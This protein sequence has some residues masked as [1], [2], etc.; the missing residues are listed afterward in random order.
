MAHAPDAARTCTSA[1]APPSPSP[2]ETPLFRLTPGTRLRLYRYLGLASWNGSPY[3]FDL[4]VGRV[5]YRPYARGLRAPIDFHGLLLSCRTIH[6]EAA[7]LLYSANCFVIYYSPTEPPG[8]QPLRALTPASLRSL[9]NLKIVVNEAACHRMASS[10]CISTCCL[11][12]R[13]EHSDSGVYLCRKRH[14]GAHQAPFLS[15]TSGG[16]DDD[17][18][19]A[20]HDAKCEL[21]SVAAHMFSSIIPGRLALSLVCDIDPQHPLALDLANSIVAPFRLRSP[22][23]SYLKECRIR[24]AKTPDT[25]FYQL[26]QDAALHACGLPTSTHFSKPPRSP[27]ATTLASLPREL[28]I[29]ILEYTDLV[30]PRRQVMWSRQYRAYVVQPPPRR[31]DDSETTPNECHSYQFF[32]CWSLTSEGCFCN[33]RHAAF[34]LACKCWAP[35]G[36]TLFLI[37]SALSQEAQYVFFSRNRFIVYDYKMCPAWA[38]PSSPGQKP[39]P[40]SVGQRF[41]VSE[42]LREVVP[43]SALTHIR[44]L[45]LVFP[46]YPPSTWPGIEAVRNWWDLVDWLQ[47]KVNLQGLTLR[48]IVVDS[49]NG[50][51]QPPQI[52][53]EGGKA[54][55]TAYMDLLQP[56]QQLAK[57][58]LAEFY[59]HFAYPWE[60]VLGSKVRDEY[61]PRWIWSEKKALKHRLERY[62]MGD[63]YESLYADGKKEQVASDWDL[64]Y[65]TGFLW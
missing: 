47:D 32:D 44:F 48:I 37:C 63:R 58:G 16:S 20:A 54:V 35:P 33:R 21:H 61:N 19:A 56:L 51:P 14:R 50:A 41:A 55:M 24:L 39:L 52:T 8:L 57:L 17:A 46:P 5:D 62:V 64:V 28:R 60:T 65:F 13:E 45:E 7:A 22:T 3:Q 4:R 59:A 12:G 43:A 1:S 15:P 31:D 27:A 38:V 23:Q 2:A 29:R 11:Q 18:L 53:N 42:F 49:S 34:S 6:A 25:R 36:P 40:V 10:D 30:T 26:A 9:S